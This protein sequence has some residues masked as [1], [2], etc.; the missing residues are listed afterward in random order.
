MKKILFVFLIFV[1]SL[2]RAQSGYVIE[3]TYEPISTD[4]MMM[5]ARANSN[6]YQRYKEEAYDCYSKKD[7]YNFIYYSN[8]AL[9]T[10]FYNAKLYFDRGVAYE[11]LYDYSKAKKEYKKALKKGYYQAQAALDNLKIKQKTKKK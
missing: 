2:C 8:L 7:Y 9:K 6:R 1:S 5:S 3:E 10:G 4:L 11:K